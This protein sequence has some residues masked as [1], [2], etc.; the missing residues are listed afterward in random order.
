MPKNM[1]KMPSASQEGVMQQ[2]MIPGTEDWGVTPGRISAEA[3]ANYTQ[4]ESDQLDADFNKVIEGSTEVAQ[5]S[6]ANNKEVHVQEGRE[7]VGRLKEKLAG[8][9]ALSGDSFYAAVGATAQFCNT[10]K[11]G[12]KGLVAKAKGNIAQRKEAFRAAVQQNESKILAEEG[13]VAARVSGREVRANQRRQLS[14]QYAE[15]AALDM[16]LKKENKEA[17]KDA[18]RRLGYK[19]SRAE[20]AEARFDE[21]KYN[22]SSA[23]AETAAARKAETEARA[24]LEELRAKFGENP[25]DKAAINELRMAE[26]NLKIAEV[27]LSVAEDAQESARLEEYDAENDWAMYNKFTDKQEGLIDNMKEELSS[28]KG[29]AAARKAARRTLRRER[30]ADMGDAAVD[31]IKSVSGLIQPK[32]RAKIKS[33]GALFSNKRAAETLKNSAT[34][35]GAEHKPG[36]AEQ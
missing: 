3:P 5:D 35:V 2:D 29:K 19:Q 24:A 27:N 21:A 33:L 20:G 9:N 14:E 23:I 10:A 4:E 22:Y 11:S 28:L 36:D 31:S 6:P 7:I 17:V 26:A 34:E 12:L 15:E 18:E 8:W 16:Q 30:L 25:S 32:T 13:R 1:N